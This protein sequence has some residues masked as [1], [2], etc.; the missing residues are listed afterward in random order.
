M[1]DP[2]MQNIQPMNYN[3]LF[4]TQ[5]LGPM[6]RSMSLPVPQSGAMPISQG[7]QSSPEMNHLTDV[8]NQYLQNKQQDA[9]GLTQ[10]ILSQR[11]QPTL[12]DTSKSITQT[13]Q[14]Y[15][16]PGMFNPA[17]PEQ[18][19]AQR[20]SLELAPY[21]S[22]AELQSKLGSSNM[23]NAGGATGVLVNR[24]MASDPSLS[25]PQALQL[26][27]TGYRQGTMLGPDGRSLAVIP[28]A[29]QALG[30]VAE[31]Q[32]GGREAATL[33]FAKP[34]AAAKKTG[35]NIADNQQNAASTNDIVGLYGKLQDDAKT[36]PSGLAESAMA[37]ASNLAGMPTQGAISQATFDADLN[38]LY[39]AT[40][41]SLKG[42]GR[43]MEQE[44]VK[45]GEA[46]PKSTD[47]NA[48][49]I[50]KAKTHMAYYTKRMQELGVDPST[51]QPM[52]S[53]QQPAMPNTGGATHIYNSV[54]GQLEQVQ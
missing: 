24:V 52:Q 41:R 5:N 4:A 39:L 45:I 25:F 38:N 22:M 20:G 11:F 10:Q 19:A 31:G 30:A 23:N 43:V 46:A 3:D 28:G 9:G 27:Q 26:V 14:S 2:T 1:F 51:G 8:L 33:Q 21:T 15:L 48:V 18:V 40:I 7:A 12:A 34:I 50:E 37:R 32:Q 16:A 42:T 53:D 6:S 17:S 13:A 47:S 36:T 29:P 44:L 54:T 49:K 35:E